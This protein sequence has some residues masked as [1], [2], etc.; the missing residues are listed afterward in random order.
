MQKV[1]IAPQMCFCPQPLYIIGTR[2]EDGSPN[3]CAL[4]WVTFA[5][6]GTPTVVLS[7]GEPKV[8]RSNILREQ[9]FVANQVGRKSVWLADY[10]GSTTAAQGPKTAMP[11]GYTWGTAVPAP[12]LDESALAFECCVARSIELEGGILV[13]GKV[14]NVQIAAQ[15]AGMDLDHV[16]LQ[17][18]DPVIYAP[19][20]YWSVG[21]YLGDMGEWRQHQAP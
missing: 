1:N 4:S 5:W 3:F 20:N 11:Y 18:L 13:L 7:I 12:V 6:N 8:T 17:A 14:E 16:D 15:F 19:S 2:N 21:A 9:A 10:F